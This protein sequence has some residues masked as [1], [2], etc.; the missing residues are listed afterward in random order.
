[1]VG[2]LSSDWVGAVY[3]PVLYLMTRFGRINKSVNKSV[4]KYR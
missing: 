4:Q 1:M 3:V 2:W